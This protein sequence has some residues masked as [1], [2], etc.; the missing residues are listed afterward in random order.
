MAAWRGGV[1]WEWKR[2][3]GGSEWKR[4]NSSERK[5]KRKQVSVNEGRTNKVGE[6]EGTVV[7]TENEKLRDEKVSDDRGRPLPLPSPRRI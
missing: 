4:K 3:D 6:R 1:G 5:E 2:K 7:E